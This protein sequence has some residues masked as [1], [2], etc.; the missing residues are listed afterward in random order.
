MRSGPSTSNSISFSVVFGSTTTCFASPRYST[1]SSSCSRVRSSMPTSRSGR[2]SKTPPLPKS[3]SHNPPLAIA[4]ICPNG[5]DGLARVEAGRDHFPSSGLRSGGNAGRFSHI[6][7]AADAACAPEGSPPRPGAAPGAQS[8]TRGLSGRG[9][10]PARLLLL[11]ARVV[12]HDLLLPLLLLPLLLLLS[13]VLALLA[14][15]L[16]LRRCLSQSR[17]GHRGRAS[18]RQESAW[19]IERGS[20]SVPPGDRS[21]V[22]VR[23]VAASGRRHRVLPTLGA[24]PARSEQE[25]APREC[26]RQY[27]RCDAVCFS[28][29][30][31]A[32]RGACARSSSRSSRRGPHRFPMFPRHACPRTAAGRRRAPAAAARGRSRSAD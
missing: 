7:R 20:S 22:A 15:V 21:R 18:S 14:L 32:R 1:R 10:D 11:P 4:M 9:I 31:Q 6:A 2:N 3:T 17:R 8:A 24:T 12:L 30:N 5:S 23:P 13:P 25:V 26:A 29:R 28:R 19:K 27:A 16:Q